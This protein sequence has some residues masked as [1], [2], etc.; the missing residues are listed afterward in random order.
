MVMEY[1]RIPSHPTITC[2]VIRGVDRRP[3]NV[4]FLESDPVMQQRSLKPSLT[5]APA[6][7]PTIKERMLDKKVLANPRSHSL[8]YIVLIIDYIGTTPKITVTYKRWQNKGI[9]RRI[10]SLMREVEVEIISCSSPTSYVA[11]NGRKLKITGREKKQNRE[12][13][14]RVIIEKIPGE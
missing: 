1:K 3:I 8:V 4:P 5:Y 14:V 12:S 13:V 2:D 10:E 7:I 11:D 9:K 6:C